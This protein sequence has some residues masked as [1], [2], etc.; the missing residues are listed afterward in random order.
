[1]ESFIEILPQTLEGIEQYLSSGIIKGIGPKTA[2]LIVKQF[3]LRTFEIMEQYPDKLKEIRGIT[4]KKMDAIT[5]SFQGSRILRDLAVYLM[6][7]Q[8]SM[9]KVQKIYQEFGA[10]SLDVVKK[11]QS[12]T[13]TVEMIYN[14]VTQ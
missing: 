2:K 13:E 14:F 7:F 4:D 10:N 5:N 9:K 1:M 12:L 6:P 3:G 11:G 8:V